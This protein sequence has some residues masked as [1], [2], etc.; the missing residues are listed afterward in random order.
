MRIGAKR[1]GQPGKLY[2]VAHFGAGAVRF[3]VADAARIDTRL[4]ECRTHQCAL[5]GWIGH[6]VPVGP[7]AVIDVTRAND[8]MDVVTVCDRA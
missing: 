6:C 4:V 5:C 8:R 7:A 3:D 2:R 1:L